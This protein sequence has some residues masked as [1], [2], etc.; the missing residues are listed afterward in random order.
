MRASEIM[1]TPVSSVRLGAPVADAATVLA[2]H[3][4]VAVPVV[5]EGGVLAGMVTMAGI[6]SSGA[7]GSAVAAEV[8]STPV[9]AVPVDADVGTVRRT[10]LA[11]GQR[12][13][14]VVDGSRLVGII[15]RRNLALAAATAGAGAAA[16]STVAT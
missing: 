2:D 11:T 1:T 3:G 5:A 16:A 8:M 15:T 10:M 6:V 13:L 4:Y 12:A 7:E 9:T 14:P